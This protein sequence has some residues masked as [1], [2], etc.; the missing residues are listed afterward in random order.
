MS[1]IENLQGQRPV[2]VQGPAPLADIELPLADHRA[3]DGHLSCKDGSDVPDKMIL[4]L[5]YPVHIG[6][7]SLPLQVSVHSVTALSGE[8]MIH[9]K[10][11]H[12]RGIGGILF[13]AHTDLC[14]S[15]GTLLRSGGLHTSAA[16]LA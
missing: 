11:Y 1:G 14:K 13:P 6:S 16:G 10:T 9:D 3:A 4:P 7:L 5:K 8:Y 12:I 2:H 15:W